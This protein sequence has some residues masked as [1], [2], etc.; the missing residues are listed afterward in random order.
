MTRNLDLS[1][2]ANWQLIYSISIPPTVLSTTR[3]KIDYARITPIYPGVILDKSILAITVGTTIPAGRLWFFAGT[4]LRFAN[5]SFGK[6][7]IED[8]KPLFLNGFNLVV[9]DVLSNNYQLEVRVPKWFLSCNLSVYQYEGDDRT[10][11]EKDLDI[12]KSAV[13]PSS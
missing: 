1:I 12:I 10:L 13:V 8:P 3:N 7:Y 6:T 11:A 4:L 2:G 9:S 5:S